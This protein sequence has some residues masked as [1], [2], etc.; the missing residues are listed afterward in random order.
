M[1]RAGKAEFREVDAPGGSRGSGECRNSWPGRIVLFKAV[2]ASQPADL[3]AVADNGWRRSIPR[4]EVRRIDM[5]HAALLD[6]LHAPEV[7]SLL[8]AEAEG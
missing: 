3:R 7:A 8:L 4:L 1:G 5:E 2:H 6:H